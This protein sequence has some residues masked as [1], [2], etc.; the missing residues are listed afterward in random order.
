MQSKRISFVVPVYKVDIKL[1][2]R[3]IDSIYRQGFDENEQEVILVIDGE[4]EN[5]NVI[6]DKE[7]NAIPGLRRIVQEH[8]GEARARNKGMENA[9]SD[10]LCFVDADDYLIE[11]SI[12]WVMEK[13]IS[14]GADFVTSNHSRSYGRQVIP[15]LYYSKEQTIKGDKIQLISDVLSPGSDQGTVWGKI[16]NVHFLRDNEL[17]FDSKLINGVDQEFMIRCCMHAGCVVNVPRQTYM[18]CINNQSVVRS[19]SSDYVEIVRKTIS[20]ISNEIKCYSRD[21]R[22]NVVLSAYILDRLLL[23]IMNYVFHPE[24]PMGFLRK[25][26]LLLQ[27]CASSPFESA[28]CNSDY[29]SFSLP[30]RIVLFC[31]RKHF[32]SPIAIISMVRHIQ[33]RCK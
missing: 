26:K 14:G 23:I 17:I 11:N 8:G 10:W 32:I 5:K 16:F 12:A 24:S 7:L 9:K 30:K 15:I 31:L 18:Y 13:G 29:S 1:L 21:D 2:K 4:N 3:C 19:F 6:M 25:R 33:L 22:I 27:I 20:T 28:L